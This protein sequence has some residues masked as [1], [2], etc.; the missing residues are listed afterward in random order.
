M[1]NGGRI[2]VEYDDPE[3]LHFSDDLH[4]RAKDA[5]LCNERFL[6]K[7]GDALVWSASLM[8]GGSPVEHP[9]Q[10]RKS[11]VTH[12]CPADLQPMFAYK[13]GRGKRKLPSGDY[14]IAECW[15]E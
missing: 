5:G 12:Y 15:D 8:H 2:W 1:F 3:L 11:L 6:P 9:N 7:K 10:T 13:G 4:A 14:V